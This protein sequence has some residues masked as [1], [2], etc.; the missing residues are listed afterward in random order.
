[1]VVICRESGRS[2]MRERDR[3]ARIQPGPSRGLRLSALGFAVLCGRDKPDERQ[4]QYRLVVR[5]RG[6]V[7][8]DRD[9]WTSTEPIWVQPRQWPSFRCVFSPI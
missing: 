1:M 3:G 8:A 9:G 2:S 4:L 5:H 6:C 7:T